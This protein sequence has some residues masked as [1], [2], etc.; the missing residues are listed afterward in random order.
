MKKTLFPILIMLL[1]SACSVAKINDGEQYTGTTID[2]LQDGQDI[3]AR[4][5]DGLLTV[6]ILAKNEKCTGQFQYVSSTK[7]YFGFTTAAN[8]YVGE[9]SKKLGPACEAAIGNKGGT[10]LE[11]QVA[12]MGG[13]LGSGIMSTTVI[14]VCED[15]TGVCI[16]KNT[17]KVTKD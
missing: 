2:L 3:N 13:L 14:R 5:V 8:S 9:F 1:L 11:L 16:P 15:D 12:R 7:S 17:F 4:L 10:K 6:Q